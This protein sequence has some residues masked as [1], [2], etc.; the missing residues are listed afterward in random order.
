[1]AMW[2]WA[3]IRSGN[4]LV[5]DDTKPIPE[6]MLTSHNWGPVSFSW[7]QIHSP[8]ANIL[9]NDF[10]NFTFKTTAISSTNISHGT[11]S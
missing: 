6:T 8:Q 1:M 5:P 10:E 2:I 4:G 3:N 11:G 9:Y 7:N